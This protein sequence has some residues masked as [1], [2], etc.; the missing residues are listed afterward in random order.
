[1]DTEYLIKLANRTKTNTEHNEIAYRFRQMPNLTIDQIDFV[2]QNAY[3]RYYED[4]FRLKRESQ[5]KEPTVF[6]KTLTAAQL[7][8]LNNPLWTVGLSVDIIHN[9]LMCYDDAKQE[10]WADQFGDL[11]DRFT[12]NNY[13]DIYSIRD[14]YI[15]E[16][17]IKT[18]QH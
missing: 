5:L 12:A 18:W 10:D 13:E 6:E 16:K 7:F 9:I 2:S 3:N 17:G 11:L 8:I 1:M 15:K 14:N 4:A